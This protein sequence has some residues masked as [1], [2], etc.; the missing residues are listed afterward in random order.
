MSLTCPKCGSNEVIY[1]GT[2]TTDFG[3]YG[4]TD[5]RYTCKKCGYSGPLILDKKEKFIHYE[6]GK[7]YWKLPIF[8]V[9][10]LGLLSLLAIAWG[11]KVEV[12]L[13]FFLFFALIL[14]IFFHFVKED[15][16]VPVEKDLEKLDDRGKLKRTLNP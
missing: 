4:A 15:E 11:E 2:T 16:F 3:G 14:G 12:A 5:Q 13:L 8:W 6:Q 1:S 9:M 7:S 10:I